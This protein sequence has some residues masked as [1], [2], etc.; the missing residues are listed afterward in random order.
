MTVDGEELARRG[1]STFRRWGFKVY[2]GALYVPAKERSRETILEGSKKKLILCYHRSVTADLFVEKSEEILG[3]NP[4]NS[5]AQM[6]AELDRLN[7]LYVSVKKGDRYA[8]TYEPASTT[9]RL[10]FNDRELGSFVDPAFAR[11]YFGI[12]L[13]DYSVSDRFTA[14]LFGDEE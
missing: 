10:F 2:T 13:S 5:L 1:M 6:R 11:A 4:K 3:R 9:M 14:G 7:S 12:W 8:I